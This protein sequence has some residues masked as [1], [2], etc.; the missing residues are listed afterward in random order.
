MF[1]LLIS[2]NKYFRMDH[3]VKNDIIIFQFKSIINGDTYEFPLKR[4]DIERY[5]ESNTPKS[6]EIMK[7]E[8]V[9]L[10]RDIKIDKICLKV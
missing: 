5:N 8:L 9:S 3:I 1:D 2:Y 10:I 4:T 7:S 6:I